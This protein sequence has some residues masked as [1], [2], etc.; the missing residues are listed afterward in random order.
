MVRR[1]AVAFIALGFVMSCFEQKPAV[2]PTPPPTQWGGPPNQWPAPP[3]P[4]TTGGPD[5]WTVYGQHLMNGMSTAQ[6]NRYGQVIDINY[7]AWVL[8]Q[9]CRVQLAPG[10]KPSWGSKSAL[11]A[12]DAAHLSH[13]IYDVPV[14]SA[15][16][17][18]HESI[19]AI[20]EINGEGGGG[21]DDRGERNAYFME[22]HWTRWVRRLVVV[23]SLV[24]QNRLDAARNEFMAVRQDWFRGVPDSNRTFP[25]PDASGMAILRRA[26]YRFDIDSAGAEIERL[27]GVRFLTPPGP[28]PG[29]QPG[30]GPQPASGGVALYVL[31]NASNGMW[32]GDESQLRTRTRCSFEGGGVGCNPNDVVTY[33]VLVGPPNADA[34]QAQKTACAAF[35]KKHFYP[36]GIGWKATLKADGKTYGVWDDTVSFLMQ[37]VPD[38]PP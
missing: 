22:A 8:R 1:L 37:C 38:G 24:R 26:G 13:C 36:I 15:S 30:P 6:L 16:T 4:P 11:N 35:S 12:G 23:E 21:A 32:F 31:T 29:P 20:E 18:F 7:L 33:K 34:T 3:P 27:T 2:S 10:Q 19:H 17:I 9:N 25:R 14:A 5:A 28:Q